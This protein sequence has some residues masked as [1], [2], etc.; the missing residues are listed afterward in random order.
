M[1]GQGSL[2]QAGFFHHHNPRVRGYRCA[3]A[4]AGL[5]IALA[6]ATHPAMSQESAFLPA[7]AQADQTVDPTDADTQA[8]TDDPSQPVDANRLRI[9]FDQNSS[10]FTAGESI[11]A[12]VEVERLTDHASTDLTLRYSLYRVSHG[13]TV[14]S[15]KTSLRIDSSGSGKPLRIDDSVPDQAGVYELR[16]SIETD[17][18]SYWVRLRRRGK[19]IAQM[20]LPVLVLRSADSAQNA[21]SAQ[22]DD[23]ARHADSAQNADFTRH[24]DSEQTTWET[25]GTIRPSEPAWSVGQWLPEQATRLIPGSNK[26]DSSLESDTHS[27]EPV[28]VIQSGSTFQ[29]TLPVGE[30]NQPH[31]I[32]LRYPADFEGRMRVDVGHGDQQGPPA[33]SFILDGHLPPSDL[34]QPWIKHTFVYYPGG[35][36]QVWL[37]NLDDKRPARFESIEVQGGPSRIQTSDSEGPGL[38]DAALVI[39]EQ[40]WPVR[41]STDLLRRGIANT[42]TDSTR[43]LYQAWMSTERL[44]DYAAAQGFN[45]M[46]LPLPADQAD[47]TFIDAAM[48]LMT[49]RGMRCYLSVNQA[50][51]LDCSG[52]PLHRSAVDRDPAGTQHLLGRLFKEASFAGL[53][54][55][56]ASLDFASRSI[57]PSLEECVVGLMRDLPPEAKV[58]AYL[59]ALPME[60]G[61]GDQAIDGSAFR[62]RL[63]S[64]VGQ[65]LIWVESLFHQSS[66]L[67]LRQSTIEHRFTS[68][69]SLSTDRR[70]GAA[71]GQTVIAGDADENAAV[72]CQGLPSEIRRTVDGFDPSVLLVHMPVSSGSLFVDLAGALRSFTSTPA[73]LRVKVEP[74]DPSHDFVHVGTYVSENRSYISI[75][76]LAPWDNEVDLESPVGNQWEVVQGAVTVTS[77]SKPSNRQTENQV[78]KP[79]NRRIRVSLPAGSMTLLRS[80][81]PTTDSSTDGA[82]SGAIVSS[83]TVSVVGGEDAIEKIK[84]Q[85]TSIVQQI[86]TYADPD[87]YDAL[88]NGGFEQAGGMGLVGWMHA[89]HP[90][91]CVRVDDQEFIEGK[92]AIRMVTDATV[93]TRTWLVSEVIE[94][95]AS[96]RLAISMAFRGELSQDN[97]MH[98]V[99]VSIEATRDSVPERQSIEMEVPRNGQWGMREIVLEADGID[100]RTTDSLRLTVDSLSPG[101]IWIDDVRLHDYFPTERERHELQSQAFLA[102]QGLQ[103]GNLTPSARLL[104]NQWARWLLKHPKSSSSW[105]TSQPRVGSASPSG[106]DKQSGTSQPA[107]TAGGNEVE[108]STPGMAERIRGWL[109]RPLRF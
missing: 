74:D 6:H 39:S 13:A 15:K 69:G 24:D 100:P 20:G 52:N 19:P 4:L 53:V 9:V 73:E 8:A 46:I 108:P 67:L 47:P 42:C 81:T 96:G 23:S 61:A 29:A 104:Q 89:Q 98:R 68:L 16:C 44:I 21:D 2:R 56:P 76:S 86:G 25:I 83:W 92:Q 32:T 45:S 101:C 75:I 54:L 64:V 94:P 27:G 109:P 31:K 37:T 97:S 99:R 55:Q 62:A 17:Q 28:S 36:D 38:R 18:D 70:R 1:A 30:R 65:R 88:V 43:R 66:E 102:V 78:A 49:L 63:D 84:K 51:L 72:V 60:G 71:V 57:Q 85:V 11:A 87:P 35:N 48:R 79:A 50:S 3:V 41:L 33:V 91:G 80:K 40:D 7:P 59:P 105:D 77:V 10:L 95:P 26:V 22:D 107:V 58:I 34:D 14:W 12:R 93:S 106:D 103:R 90:P 82:G 5:G